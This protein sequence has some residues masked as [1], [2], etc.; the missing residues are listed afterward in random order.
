MF[1]LIYIDSKTLGSIALSDTQI[2]VYEFLQFCSFTKLHFCL[3]W[4]NIILSLFIT[5]HITSVNLLDS[6][7]KS[8]VLESLWQSESSGN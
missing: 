2:Y 6:F 3:L 8:V 4:L 1:I 5:V 7:A